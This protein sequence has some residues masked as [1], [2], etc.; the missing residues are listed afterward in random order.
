MASNYRYPVI[1]TQLSHPQPVN[2]KNQTSTD[3]D[4]ESG[5]YSVINCCYNSVDKF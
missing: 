4:V 1:E 2:N 5:N 3:P